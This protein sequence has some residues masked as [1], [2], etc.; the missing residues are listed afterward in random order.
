MTTHLRRN[1]PIRRSEL[2]AR[3]SE[4]QGQIP[5]VIPI[6]ERPASLADCA[7]P[8]HWE[9]DLGQDANYTYIATL[10]ERWSRCVKLVRVT[11]KETDVVT[12]ADSRR[13]APPGRTHGDAHVGSQ[14]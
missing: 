12:R 4:D 5:D 14:A 6:A 1:C 2:S 9:G 7:I 8:G 11:S 10:V 3:A 13:H